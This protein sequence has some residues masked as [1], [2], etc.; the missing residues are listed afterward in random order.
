MR[1]C[2]RL[3]T[4]KTSP[5]QF[6]HGL[7]DTFHLECST[8]SCLLLKSREFSEDNLTFLFRV[9]LRN[10]WHGHVYLGVS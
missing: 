10:K 8:S 7:K 3:R 9:L 2:T 6:G 1:L 4:S 5:M